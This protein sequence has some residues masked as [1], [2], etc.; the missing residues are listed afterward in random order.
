MQTNEPMRTLRTHIIYIVA[1]ILLIGLLLP[2]V[3]HA[4]KKYAKPTEEGMCPKNYRLITQ[5]A[6][7]NLLSKELFNTRGQICLEQGCSYLP[8]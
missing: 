7:Q 8:N 5:P 1:T 6:L 3:S 4:Q 2:L